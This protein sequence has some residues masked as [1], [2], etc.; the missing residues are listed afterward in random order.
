MEQNLTLADLYQKLTALE[1]TLSKMTNME[2]K[3]NTICED[4]RKRDQK[5]ENLEAEV[6]KLKKE[7]LEAK[8]SL[9]DREQYAR[10]WSVR[11]TGLT[12]TTEEEEKLGK[13]RAVMKKAYDKVIKPILISAKENGQID[14]VPTAWHSALENGHKLTV[15]NKNPNMPP[16]CI[17][18]FSSRFIRNAVLRNK[19]KCTPQPTT[20]EI[21]AGVKKYVITEDLTKTNYT[22][23]RALSDDERVEKTW[24]MDGRLRYI[25]KN[26]SSKKVNIVQNP[27]L[28]VNEILAKV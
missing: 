25:K 7:N 24:T 27:F 19:K 16:P 21:T 17:L 11:L 9:N 12:V 1:S 3:L 10:S 18:R 23:L 26:D 8:S 2:S 22:L 4:I 20:A 13:D 15:K 6:K 5:I 14:T 28:S